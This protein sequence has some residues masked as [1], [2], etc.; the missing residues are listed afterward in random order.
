MKLKYWGTAYEK[1]LTLTADLFDLEG[2]VIYTGFAMTET[3]IDSA[4]YKTI[5][6]L[7]TLGTLDAGI[8]V[9]RIIDSV[10]GDFIGHQELIFNGVE[11]ITL[12][13]LRF[14]TDI[15]LMQLRDALGIDGDKILAKGGQLQKKSESPYNDI[16]DTTNI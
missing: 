16:I 11:E 6:V 15:E 3:A 10:S 2:A 8:Y 4:I 5:N 12:F 14:L 9:V 1:G 13:Q 7:D